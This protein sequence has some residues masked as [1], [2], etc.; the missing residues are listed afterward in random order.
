MASLAC[1]HGEGREATPGRGDFV[2]TSDGEE[3]STVHGLLISAPC[4][5]LRAAPETGARQASAG[6]LSG[7]AHFLIINSSCSSISTISFQR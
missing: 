7:A 1:D 6:E 5:R 3:P 4:C 2:I